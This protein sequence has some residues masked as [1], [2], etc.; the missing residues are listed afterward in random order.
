[1]KKLL[2]IIY[3]LLT[4]TSLSAQHDYTTYSIGYLG[5]QQKVKESTEDSMLISISGGNAITSPY[6]NILD[7]TDIMVGFPF[8]VGYFPLVFDKELFVSKGYFA[9]HILLEWSILALQSRIER[10]LIYRKPLGSEGD[11]LLV[12]NIPA[13]EYN[14]KDELAEK[15]QLYKYTIF[16]KGIA[17]DLLLPFVNV[18]EGVGFAFPVGTVS[19]R[20]TYEGG[21][22]VENVVVMAETD[23]NLSGKSIYLNG[24]DAYLNIPHQA[25]DKELEIKNGFT[26][27]AWS[28]LHETQGGVLFSKGEQYQID[29]ST[30][31]ISFRVKDATVTLPFTA[32]VDSFFHISASYDPTDSLR[33][34]VQIDEERSLYASSKAGQQPDASAFDDI[35][36]GRDADGRGTY[37]KGYID[38]LRL[39]N[40]T[41]SE[42]EILRD[43]SRYIAGTEDH[44]VG[45][46]RLN[47]GL[48][49]RFFDA[50][51]KGYTFYENHG[52][53]WRAAWSEK[54][55]L[56]SQ[57]AFKGIT[58]AEGNYI[59]SGFP[60]ETGGS[61]Y[62]FTPMFGVHSFE[63][64]QHLRFVGD[65]ASIHNGL[66]FDD[67]S[68]FKVSG[69]VWYKDTY[70]PVE[71]VSIRVDGKPAINADGQL[72]VSDNLGQFTVDVPIGNHALRLEKN[73]HGFAYEGRFPAPDENTPVG[74][75]PTFNFQEPI[76][77]LE[78][79]DTTLVKVVGRIVGGPVEEQKALGFGKSNNNIG[80]AKVV[81]STEKGFDVTQ[82]FISENIEE[83]EVTN[84]V[85][86]DTKI[87]NIYP[88]TETGEYIAYLLPEKY[89]VTNITA[90]DYTFGD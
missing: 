7:Q 74:E 86:R 66:D 9:D 58:D 83:G 31:A 61:Q 4:V 33:L 5:G 35:Y 75:I 67:V 32:P 34:Y 13:D 55:P 49:D 17:D 1:M 62:T 48:A 77:G 71:G 29:V 43:Y 45:Y 70:F 76:V 82:A 39:W 63:P 51:R 69:T 14:W 2:L 80:N 6:F 46:W 22:A 23:G 30:S 40:T 8:N 47:T 79:F 21:T 11:S 37:F 28:R 88:N 3:V 59:I 72:I 44:L 50:A 27:Q 24:T 81:L 15:G 56:Q 65:G 60:Y 52:W 10:F 54:K 18:V 57:L 64:T 73:Q 42:E 89:T 19:G 84:T 41:L 68:S 16:A 36:L 25:K 26:F 90:G 38:E 87:T 85:E 78:F 53:V 20:I 12:A